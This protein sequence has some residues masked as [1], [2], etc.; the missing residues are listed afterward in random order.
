MRGPAAAVAARLRGAGLRVD[1]ALAACKAR[2]AFDVANKA[3]AR[4]VAFVGPDEWSKG[5]VRVKD[6]AVKDPATDEGLQVDVS[7]DALGDVA[8]VL[9]AAARTKGAAWVPLASAGD[10]PSAAPRAPAA[11]AILATLASGVKVKTTA[12]FSALAL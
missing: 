7:L 4:L 11:G 12:K 9:E 1:A 8:A 5:E 3:G 2:R 10:A 6:M